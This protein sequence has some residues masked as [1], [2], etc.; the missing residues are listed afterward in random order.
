MLLY[1]RKLAHYFCGKEVDM[2][3]SHIE[4]RGWGPDVT[5]QAKAL[6]GYTAR[7]AR[8][9]K[10]AR[11]A[12]GLSLRDVARIT[13]GISVSGSTVRSYEATPAKFTQMSLGIVRALS[14]VLEYDPRAILCLPP[15][16][17]EDDA[18]DLE[19]ASLE[20]TCRGRYWA[21]G[22]EPPEGCAEWEVYEHGRDL[23]LIVIRDGEGGKVGKDDRRYVV[24]CDAARAVEKLRDLFA[25]DYGFEQADLEGLRDKLVLPATWRGA[26]AIVREPA[27]AITID[28]D[29]TPLHRRRSL[30]E[31]TAL[32]RL[33][34][35]WEFRE[36]D[37]ERCPHLALGANHDCEVR[38]FSDEL[39]ATCEVILWHVPDPRRQDVADLNGSVRDVPC[40]AKAIE[41]A[42]EHLK[43]HGSEVGGNSVSYFDIA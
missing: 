23:S 18:A 22:G 8:R 12:R 33:G 35:G 42:L 15:F 2:P 28:Y 5:T 13:D 40:H 25:L 1:V 3:V 26:D 24:P 4:G 16:D 20:P 7:V 34:P 41:L 31:R 17:S 29:S 14:M 6:G 39:G 30:W 36:D 38:G 27:P 9:I 11:E 19:R 43:E 21:L 10:A 32:S 37:G